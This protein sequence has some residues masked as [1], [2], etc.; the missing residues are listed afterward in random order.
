LSHCWLKLKD[1]EKWKGSFKLWYKDGKRTTEDNDDEEVPGK[2]RAYKDRP[3]GHKASK[4]DLRRQASF[5][6]LENTLKSVFADKE[7]ASAKRDERR[8]RDEEQMQSFT[9]I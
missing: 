2:G 5:L 6:A 4:T 7:E 9:D 1:F 3:R 8:R